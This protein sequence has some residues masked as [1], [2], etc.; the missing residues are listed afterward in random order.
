[1]LGLKD[2][3]SRSSPNRSISTPSLQNIDFATNGILGNLGASVLAP[4]ESF[5]DPDDEEGVDEIEMLG[6][7]KVAEEPVSTDIDVVA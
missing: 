7:E 4:G 2:V 1:M 6:P 5:F 3:G